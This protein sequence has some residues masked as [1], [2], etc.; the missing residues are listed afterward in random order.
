MS[1][2]RRALPF[3]AFLAGGR[4]AKRQPCG[5]GRF[6]CLRCRA[7]RPP[8][9]EMVD[10]VATSASGMVGTLQALCPACDGL[11][12]RRTSRTGEASAM[13]GIAIQYHEQNT[14]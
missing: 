11:M 12:Q 6:Y 5:P 10:F 13:P 4:K 14:T 3:R 1:G 8:A 7:P 9:G 2:G